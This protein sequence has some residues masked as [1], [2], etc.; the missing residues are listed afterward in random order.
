MDTLS[1]KTLDITNP[2]DP[3]LYISSEEKK[4]LKFEAADALIKN[5][6]KPAGFHSNLYYGHARTLLNELHFCLLHQDQMRFPVFALFLDNKIQQAK[7]IF[8][9]TISLFMTI[10]LPFD[11]DA[12]DEL[13]KCKKK[14]EM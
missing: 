12:R 6:H 4:F 14:T 9:F 13:M 3:S 11:Y 7:N 8:H 1:A 10:M 5:D 2:D